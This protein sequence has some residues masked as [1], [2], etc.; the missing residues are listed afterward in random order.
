MSNKILD[1]YTFINKIGSGSFGEIYNIFCKKKNKIIAAKIENK[2]KKKQ[3][4]KLEY[5]IYTEL[6][7]K[8]IEGILKIYGFCETQDYNIM[9]LEK[10]DKNLQELLM[11]YKKLKKETIIKLAIKLIRIIRDI[12]NAG[13]LHRDI[14]PNNFMIKLKDDNIKILDF[15]LSKKYIKNSK[16]IPFRNDR[17]M[18][19]T[20]RYTSINM[21]EGK[22]YSRRD[23]IESICYMLIYLSKGTLPWQKKKLGCNIKNIGIM[24]K[25]T[26]I[27]ELC[28]DCI[29]PLYYMLKY[30]RSLEFYDEPDYNYMEN[31][32]I[33]YCKKKKIIPY[34][35]WLQ[36]DNSNSFSNIE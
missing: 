21:H 8:N 17:K 1:K 15:G 2:N 24:K 33:D 5:N 35:E 11:R 20:A 16:H 34:F 32:F 28:K 14:K 4:L 9:Y 13:F 36:V 10:M 30:C 25:N 6:K 19:G 23:D 29:E 18:V 3:R 7:K 22:E 12:H 31:L 26:N 27:E